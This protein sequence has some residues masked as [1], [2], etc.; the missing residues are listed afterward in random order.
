MPLPILKIRLAQMKLLEENAKTLFLLDL[1]RYLRDRYANVLEVMGA[2][3]ADIARM[4]AERAAAYGIVSG[5]GIRRVT[6]VMLLLGPR[7]YDD[8]RYGWKS[9]H[10]LGTGRPGR[11]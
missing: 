10:G 5:Y 8:P 6:E 7:F 9:A 1:E 4:G 11:L 2:R 3:A